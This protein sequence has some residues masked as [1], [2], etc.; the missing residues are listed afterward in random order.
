[1]FNNSSTLSLIEGGVQLSYRKI[2]TLVTTAISMALLI[3]GCVSAPQISDLTLKVRDSESRE[4]KENS[5]VLPG[6]TLKLSEILGIGTKGESHPL[7]QK[8]YSVQVKGGKYNAGT[9]EFKLEGDPA[10]IPSDGYEITVEH[11]NGVRTVQKFIPDIA[12][13]QGP[14][15]HEV[16]SFEAKLL[17]EKDGAKYEITA[18]TP[19]IPGEKYELQTNVSDKGGR[20]FS[21]TMPTFPVPDARLNTEL[22]GF[23]ST[24]ESLTNLVAGKQ[25]ASGDRNRGGDSA[26]SEE[27]GAG[28]TSGRSNMDSYKI[29]VSYVDNDA[30]SAT[31]TFPYDPAIANGPGSNIVSSVELTGELSDVST[32]GPGEVKELG[33]S[34]NDING[35]SWVLGMEGKGS[36]YDHQY[37]LPKSRISIDVENGDYHPGSQKISFNADARSMLGQ[38]FG[39]KVK[40]DQLESVAQR[41]YSP[42][43][44][45][46]VPLMDGDEILFS[47]QFGNSGRD[48]REGQKGSRGNESNREFGRAGNARAGGHGTTGQN[49]AR[50]LPGPN[51]RVVAREVRTLDAVTRLALFEVR[52]PGEPPE[53]YVR[54]LNDLPVNV[55]SQGGKGGAG[56]QGGAGG[57]GGN[58]GDGYFSGSGGDG[59]NAGAGGDGGDGGNGGNLSVILSTRELERTFVLDSQGGHGGTG[60][61][62][63]IA[64]QPGIP[65]SVDMWQVDEKKNEK[66]TT[67]PESGAYGNEGNIGYTGRDGHSGIPGNIEM[68]VDED[69]AAALIRRTPEKIKSVVIY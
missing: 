49:G 3:G 57:E 28:Q 18:G 68:N 29:K 65:G 35:R 8:D 62:E 10:R 30:L 7:A 26:V 50:G 60:G 33:V 32:I 59:G 19:L 17:W 31:L 13:I 36:H 42:D 51:I 47:G 53:F 14:A 64:G 12:R 39:V 41:S 1:M 23:K 61:V 52:V 6:S 63:G 67:L 66:R 2:T 27:A 46:I 16:E 55:V 44:L 56:G 45:S 40:Y 69:Q 37:P 20:S 11:T 15:A 54:K 25:A 22:T 5:Q 48:G 34:V 4:L 9:R 38:K 43:F 58:G 24:G 21:T